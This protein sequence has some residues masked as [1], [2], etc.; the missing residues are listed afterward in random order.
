[1]AKYTPL[2][3][4]SGYNLN[5]INQNFQSIADELNNK[6]LYRNPPSGEPNQWETQQDANSN[7]LI[8]LPDA[9]T[10]GEPVT[11]RQFQAG[12]VGVQSVGIKKGKVVATSG[13]TVFE[14]PPYVPGS[15]NLSV[16]INGVRQAGDAYTETSS[17]S[18]T[19]S[20]G[21]AEG[22]VVEY[23]INEMPEQQ[24]TI[25]ASSVLY[26]GT[27]VDKYLGYKE[28][29]NV[30]AMKAN[31]DIQEGEI[32]RTRGW[33]VA[34]DDGAAEYYINSTATP[35]GS[36]HIQ[37]D[38]GLVASLIHNG[39]ILLEKCGAKGDGITNDHSPIK[40]ALESGFDVHGKSTSTYLISSGDKIIPNGYIKVYNV[41]FKF[42][43][44]ETRPIV[45]KN[46]FSVWDNVTMEGTSGI[47]HSGFIIQNSSN[48]VFKGCVAKKMDFYGFTITEDTDNN[49]STSCD[50]IYLYDCV[51]EDCGYY[52]F[53]FFPKT[54]SNNHKLYNCVSIRCG[55][56]HPS[57]GGGFKIG[58]ATR[59]TY[60]EGLVTIDCDYGYLIANYETLHI[61][62]TSINT[63]RNAVVIT[64]ADWSGT[65]GTYEA[66]FEN[67]VLKIYVDEDES[68][69]GDSNT[70]AL[71]INQSAVT[72]NPSLIDIREFVVNKFTGSAFDVVPSQDI[73]A[74]V[75]IGRLIS[76]NASGLQNS[77][78]DDLGGVIQDLQIDYCDVDFNTLNNVN[79]AV[80]FHSPNCRIGKLVVR[81][82][83]QYPV[84]LKKD[85][86]IIEELVI[87]RCNTT[88][89]AG[90]AG[91]LVA[92]TTPVRWDISSIT[93]NNGS[94]GFVTNL[95]A[96][97]ASGP[98][99]GYGDVKSD[100]AVNLR[101][102]SNV[103][104]VDMKA[105]VTIN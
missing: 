43:T 65:F 66:S 74:K 27:S 54:L 53:E 30:A 97:S 22:D 28:V 90:R 33:Y 16:Y 95:L 67:V 99:V 100:T 6:V 73:T 32:V 103:N 46:D 31:T 9:V 87:D 13:Q 41:R 80:K 62:G 19:L 14:V 45:I 26:N 24:G 25:G 104:V 7:R 5:T 91:V 55:N 69:V 39:D 42:S 21:A 101:L 38:N 56:L 75:K 37:L 57:A 82:G 79:C 29:D 10:A 3:V 83:G 36:L 52:G 98:T 40:A 84:Q 34:G 68:F 93:V 11:L 78:R 64:I 72:N 12:S 20:Q 48:H 94:T 15:N 89:V 71:S 96:A 70:A 2:T 49:T 61:S 60:A 88:N 44:S 18:F 85:G 4:K 58:Q 105:N 35:N 92:E 102:N 47:F 23:V 77:F 51:A 50:N 81:N 8:N 59:N 17:T 86:G 76:K 1:M 63:N